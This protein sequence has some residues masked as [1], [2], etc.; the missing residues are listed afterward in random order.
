MTDSFYDKHTDYVFTDYNR[1]K[2]DGSYTVRTQ[3]Q[4]FTYFQE[5]KEQAKMKGV[6]KKLH[7]TKHEVQTK[8]A[9][10][11]KYVEVIENGSV[12]I[13][14]VSAYAVTDRRRKAVEVENK[15]VEFV[16]AENFKW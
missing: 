1:Q 7:E 16:S 8:H 9:M 6:E 12:E 3:V 5:K 4:F 15:I 13:K 10:H 11:K 14:K 2:E